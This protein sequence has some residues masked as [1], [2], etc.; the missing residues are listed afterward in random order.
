MVSIGVVLSAGGAV[1]DPWHA[2]VLAGLF[3]ATGWDARTADLVVGTSAGAI[4]AT[5]L[6]AGVS[7][8]D[9]AAHHRREPVSEEAQAIFDRVVTPWSE[10]AVDRDWRPSSPR[11]SLKAAWPPWQAEPVRLALGSLPRGARSVSALAARMSE[12]TSDRWPTDPTWVVAV[13]IHDGRRVVFGRDDVKGDIGQAVHA[14][15]AIPGVY[16]PARIGHREYI[17]GAVHSGTNADLVAPLAFD[18]VV[19]SSCMTVEPAARGWLSDPKRAWFG[20]KLDHEADVIRARGTAVMVV[21]PSAEQIELLDSSHPDA[22]RRAVDGGQAAAH[23]AFAAPQ[24]DGLRE[25]FARA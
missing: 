12:M 24:G 21:E 5:A 9:R 23:R 16:A 3:E 4:A 15:S 2:G 10:D 25:L 20:R 14:S 7:P 17:D 6:R 1:G 22:R 11:M 8:A 19:I 18:L 13:R